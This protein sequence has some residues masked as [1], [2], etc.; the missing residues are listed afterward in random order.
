MMLLLGIALWYE[1][2][3]A[4]VSAFL[5]N[6]LRTFGG[7]VNDPTYSVPDRGPPPLRSARNLLIRDAYGRQAVSANSRA[8]LIDA[9][10]L[11][12]ILLRSKETL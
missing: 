2:L 12:L 5:R 3:L 10:L 1:R 6:E 8:S 7:V 11:D 9:D 4:I